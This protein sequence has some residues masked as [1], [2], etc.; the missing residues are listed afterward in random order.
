MCEK[1]EESCK[2]TPEMIKKLEKEFSM[3]S[4]IR[5][6]FKMLLASLTKYHPEYTSSIESK[7]K[8]LN[9]KYR[10]AHFI[11]KGDMYIFYCP[12][13]GTTITILHQ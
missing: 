7:E 4:D 2:L 1:N 12:Y 8:C 5:T 9:C 13:C 10:K 11:I 3:H 6:S